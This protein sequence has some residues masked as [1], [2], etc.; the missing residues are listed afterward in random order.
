M[1]PQCPHAHTHTHRERL[2]QTLNIQHP[3]LVVNLQH[4][5]S[6]D[7]HLANQMKERPAYYLEQLESAVKKVPINYLLEQGEGANASAG[8]SLIGT[9]GSVPDCHV[10]LVSKE[11]V[12]PVREI[13]SSMISKL[14]SLSGVI[15]SASS[16]SAKA[17]QIHLMCKSCR[18]VQ[19]FPVSAGFSGIQLPRKCDSVPQAGAKDCPLDPYVIVH[20]KSAFIDQQTLK[21]QEAHGM[22]PVGEL[23]RHMLLTA[24]RYLTGKVIPGSRVTVTGIYSIYSGDQGKKGVGCCCCCCCSY[25]LASPGL[26][27]I[28]QR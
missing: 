11:N 5:A 24:D 8:A 16:L 7:A 27:I 25:L 23:P 4:V 15:V 6:F 2:R 9:K 1:L 20:D 28:S 10:Q 19:V 17:T 18:H 14:V 12:V 3:T 21:L 13:D 22:V 26:D